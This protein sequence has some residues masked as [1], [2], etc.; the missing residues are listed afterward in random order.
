MIELG[1]ADEA[2]RLFGVRLV[3]FTPETGRKLLLS[4]LFVA[5][6]ALAARLVDAG[7]RRW[8]PGEDRRQTRF[9]VR[10]ATRL[11]ATGIGLLLLLSVW[12]DNPARLATGLGLVTAGLAVALQRVVTA[13][14]A[15]FVIL[16]GRLFRVGDRIVMGGV[17]GDVI[18]LGFIRT[19]VMEMGEPPPV[20]S[21]EPA[22]WVH[23]RQ[24]TGRVVTITNDK[25]FDEPVYNYTRDFPY[26]W[27]EMHLPIPYVADRARAERI[28]LEA[29]KRHAV[30]PDEIG[31]ARLDRLQRVYFISR[32]D[33]EPRVYWHLTD[34]WVELNVR[35]LTGDHGVRHVKDAISREI[36]RGLDEAGIQIASATYDIVGFP[37]VRIERGPAP[38]PEEAG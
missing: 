18:A 9:W 6:L 5:A 8:L 4:I 27:E 10:Q 12:F 26:L 28:I 21:D 31:A 25:I 36:L 34:N 17:R 22:V 1:A 32:T 3:G 37:P 19:T 14:A 30:S 11:V 20:Q 35:F 33:I 13:F 15:Y 16:R 23:A 24:F 2:L 38:G 29:A 7:A